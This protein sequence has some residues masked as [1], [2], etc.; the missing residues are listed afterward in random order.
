MYV[1]T[2][3][4]ILVSEQPLAMVKDVPSCTQMSLSARPRSSPMQR[5]HILAREDSSLVSS[6]PDLS[7]S[8]SLRS[9]GHL[10]VGPLALRSG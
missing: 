9:A 8:D 7:P 10:M 5:G 6:V 1:H 4:V 2:T 3:F